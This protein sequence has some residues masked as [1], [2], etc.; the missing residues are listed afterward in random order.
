MTSLKIALLPLAICLLLPHKSEVSGKPS[1]K[2]FLIETKAKAKKNSDYMPNI[3]QLRC[4][5]CITTLWPLGHFDYI[6]DIG[7]K[8][9]NVGVISDQSHN[10]NGNTQV[11]SNNKIQGSTINVSQDYIDAI[12]NS[13]YIDTIIDGSTNI[14]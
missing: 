10:V 1:P 7:N 6:D 8:K 3:H 4:V 12:N 13:G 11:F 5:G 2:Y 9:G 14:G